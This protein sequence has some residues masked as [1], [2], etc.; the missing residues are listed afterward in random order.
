MN[1]DKWTHVLG[2]TWCLNLHVTIPVYFLNDHEIVLLDTGYAKQDRADLVALLEE[3]H[4]RVRAI[5]GSHSHNDHSGNHAY[6]QKKH[7]A[8]VILHDVEAAIVSD[9]SLMTV[10]YSPG[11]VEDMK[12]HFSDLLLRADRAFRT[13]DPCVEIDGA[14]FGIIPLPGHTPGHT[15]I[16]T[17]DQVFYV[18]DAVLSEAVLKSAKLPSTRDWAEDI[19]TK[20]RMRSMSYPKYILAHEGIHED[21][22]TFIELNIEDKVA[23]AAQ[24]AAWLREAGPVTLNEAE[25]LLW[26]KLELRS[27][28]FLSQVVFRRNA[29]CALEY[30]MHEKQIA[31]SAQNGAEVFEC[32]N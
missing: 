27:Q 30:L 13:E 19:A 1:H 16:V 25:Q 15:G 20:E 22:S 28:K 18:G 29:R 23:R 5:L 4:L 11:T 12:A 24:I 3:K 2:N 7:G 31:R 14:P 9:Y 26:T 17:P 6:F 21:I 10:A 32:I 8:E